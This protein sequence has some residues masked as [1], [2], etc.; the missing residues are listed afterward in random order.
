M[1]Y[2]MIKSIKKNALWG[3]KINGH[4]GEADINAHMKTMFAW[5]GIPIKKT[6]VFYDCSE[7]TIKEFYGMV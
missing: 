4:N 2:G 1:L 3:S 5:Y 7:K 6:G